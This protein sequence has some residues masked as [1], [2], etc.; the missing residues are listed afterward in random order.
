MAEWDLDTPPDRPSAKEEI[1]V[2]S[3][4]ASEPAAAP[5]RPDAG[6]G[7]SRNGSKRR[8]WSKYPAWIVAGL[9]LVLVGALAGFF[10]VRSQWASD[11]AELVEVREELAAV[12]S[13]LT[14]A[15]ERNWMYYRKTEALTA[16]LEEA[17]AGGATTTS[18][19]MPGPVA[20]GTFGDGVYLVGEDIQPGVYDGA[21]TGEA[22]YWA[23]LKATDGMVSSIVANGLP[24]GPFVLTIVE[25]DRAVELRGVVI[26]AR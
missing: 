19:T 2:S 22:G 4:Q 18:T 16:Q 9:L 26:T 21:V 1:A 6:A 25:S 17:L 13:A 14:L 5:S 20:A 24:R 10:I 3:R 23:R 11:S 15:E 7:E 8:V 12:R